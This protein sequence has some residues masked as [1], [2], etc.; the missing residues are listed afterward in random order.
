MARRVDERGRVGLGVQVAVHGQRIH[1][2]AHDRVE[3]AE[4]AR[5]RGVVAR[6]HLVQGGARG[7]EIEQAAEA[8]RVG[9]TE[10]VG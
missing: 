4:R 8:P 1:G 6:V 2:R 3:T 5:A 9:G 7:T 10:L